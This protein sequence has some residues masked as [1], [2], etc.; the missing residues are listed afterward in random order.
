MAFL[1]LAPGSWMGFDGIRALTVGD[2]VT[3]RTGPYAGQLGPW[4]LVVGAVGLD[5]RGTP[6]KLGFVAFGAA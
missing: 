1:A 2:Y 4:R 5:P 6:M 3:P